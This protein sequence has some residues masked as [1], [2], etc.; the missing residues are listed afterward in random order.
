MLGASFIHVTNETRTLETRK[1]YGEN[2]QMDKGTS[3]ATFKHLSM[4]VYIVYIVYRIY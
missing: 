2:R 3:I 4:Y 1:V